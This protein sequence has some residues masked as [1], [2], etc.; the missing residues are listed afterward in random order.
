MDAAARMIRG[1]RPEET[2]EANTGSIVSIVRL[3]DYLRLRFY[4]LRI[5]NKEIRSKVVQ[6]CS[7]VKG[8]AVNGYRKY[9]NWAS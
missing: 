7:R 9:E 8:K 1:I 2:A 6:L 3:T 5:V 4:S